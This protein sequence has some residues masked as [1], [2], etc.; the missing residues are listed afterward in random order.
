M[1]KDMNKK[2]GFTLIELLIVILIIGI[3]ASI[4]VPMQRSMVKKSVLAEAVMGISAIRN[5][6]RM[7]KVEYGCYQDYIGWIGAQDPPAGIKGRVGNVYGTGDLDGTFFS[8]ECY[9]LTS[10]PTYF[11]A[12]CLPTP[13][14]GTQNKSPRKKYAADL[15]P[16]SSGILMDQDGD[17]TTINIPDSGYPNTQI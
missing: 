1:A 8:E 2:A 13:T 17:I 10:H 6:Q 11:S 5:A 12:K 9:G 14:S 3:L 7:Y 15:F 16:G 4:A